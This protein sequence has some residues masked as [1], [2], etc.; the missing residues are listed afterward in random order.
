M[1]EHHHQ[2]GDG[3][4]EVDGTI[5]AGWSLLSEMASLSPGSST[6]LRSFDAA[7]PRI[8]SSIA[9]TTPFRKGSFRIS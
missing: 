5:T 6:F 2:D 3:A 1:P 9:A 8:P 7:H 4:Q